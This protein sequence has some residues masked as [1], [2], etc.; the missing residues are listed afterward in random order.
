MFYIFIFYFIYFLLY[1]Y[2][3]INFI[4]ITCEFTV[5]RLHYAHRLSLH[6]VSDGLF[7]T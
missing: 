1:F 4:H 6:H 5:L 3:N 2:I 7:Y